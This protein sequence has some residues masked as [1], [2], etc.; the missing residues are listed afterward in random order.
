MAKELL[1]LLSVLLIGALTGT[2]AGVRW[3]IYRFPP[4][5]FVRAL[6]EILK[7]FSREFPP[8]SMAAAASGAALSIASFHTPA[9]LSLD[10]AAT[11][12]VVV[13]ILITVRKNVPLNIRVSA[14][15]P[16]APPVGWEQAIEQWRRWNDLR[17]AV[18]SAG[19]LALLVSI[20]FFG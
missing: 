13:M 5:L 7:V 16:D 12:S 11:V 15:T 2:L 6:Q 10:L 20:V 19:F 18:V 4:L 9:Q 3:A 14:W 1:E 8:V 17:T